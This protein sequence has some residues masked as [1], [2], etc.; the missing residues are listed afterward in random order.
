[1]HSTFIVVLLTF[2]FKESRFFSV[3]NI[4]NNASKPHIRMIYNI[5]HEN[6]ALIS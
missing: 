4:D 2:L 6:L 3:F 1:M 5:I